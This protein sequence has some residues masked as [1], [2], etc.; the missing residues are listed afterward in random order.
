MEDSLYRVVQNDLPWLTNEMPNIDNETK[1]NEEQEENE[2]IYNN[3]HSEEVIYMIEN[4]RTTKRP[5][6]YTSTLQFETKDTLENLFK[7]YSSK[8]DR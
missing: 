8:E 4:I 3:E 1:R 5:A 6:I 7:A 2:E